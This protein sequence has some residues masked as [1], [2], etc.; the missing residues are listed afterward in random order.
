MQKSGADALAQSL[1]DI[2][3]DWTAAP[4]VDPGTLTAARLALARSSIAA[5]PDVALRVSPGTTETSLATPALSS[6]LRQLAEEVH[7]AAG[8][9]TVAVVR[10]PALA[11]LANPT[12]VPGWASGGK[13]LDSYGPFLDAA[14]GLHWVDVLSITTSEQIG[15]GGAAA[16]FGVVPVR[17]SLLPL[18]NNQLKLGAGSVW[19]LASLLGSGFP[20]GA[21]TGFA[22]TG[23]T[24]V[25][26][27]PLTFQN[28]VYEAPAG[29]TLTLTAMLSSSAASGTGGSPDAAAATAQ[30]PAD[31]VIEF[32]ASTAVLQT[33]GASSMTAYG[34]SVTLQW[35]GDTPTLNADILEIPEI[36][37]PCTAS[38]SDFAFAQALSDAFAP[39]GSAPISHAAWTFPL[40][41]T[42]I[43][44]LPEAAGPG[45]ARLSLGKGATLSCGILSDTIAISGWVLEIATGTLLVAAAS[46]GTPASTTLSLWPE[47]APAG[48]LATLEFDTV[49]DSVFMLVAYTN[50]E[51]THTTGS[52][53]AHLDRPLDSSGSRIPFNSRGGGTAGLAVLRSQ[54]SSFAV[55]AATQPMTALPELSLTLENALLRVVS[56]S[57]LTASGILSGTQ[58]ST[59]VLSEAFNIAWILP[60]LPDPYAATFETPLTVDTNTASQLGTLIATTRWDGSHP[61]Q[62]SC[63]LQTAATSPSLAIPARAAAANQDRNMPAATPT[64]LY[65]LALLD[66]STNVDLFGVAIAPLLGQLALT[67]VGSIDQPQLAYNRLA[68]GMAASTQATPATFGV[69]DMTLVFNG[70]D[71]ATFA[72]PQV[73]W[74]AVETQAPSPDPVGPIFGPGSDGPPLLL[75]A[76]DNQQLVALAPQPVLTGSISNVAAGAPFAAIFSLPFGL[77]GVIAE[78]NAPPPRHLGRRRQP[79]SQFLARGGTF[80]SPTSTFPLN[81]STQLSA[82]VSLTVAPTGT[83]AVNGADP[84]FSGFLLPAGGEGAGTYLSNILGPPPVPSGP[85]SVETILFGEFGPKSAQPGVPLERIDFSGYGTSIFSEWLN[86]V[87]PPP[88]IVKVQFETTRGR[89][90]YEVIQVQ[91]VIYPYAISVVRTI[92]LQ[93]RNAGWVLRTDSGWQPVSDGLFQFPTA[94][95]SK[96]PGTVHQGALLG[97]FNVRNIAEQGGLFAVGALTYQGVSFDADLGVAGGP[98]GLNVSTGGLIDPSNRMQLVPSQQILGYVQLLPVGEPPSPLQLGQLV[99]GHGPFTPAVSFT[100]EVGSF[101]PGTAGTVLRCSAFEVGVLTT[102]VSSTSTNPPLGVALR[103]APQMPRGGGW[104]MGVRNYQNQA[105]SSL[106]DDFPVPLVQNNSTPDMW[107]IADVADIGSLQQPANLYS[108]IHATGTNKVLFEAPQIPA[109]ASAAGSSAVPGL[110]FPPI[111]SPQ[112]GAVAN[113]GS[114][115]LGDLASILGSSGLFPALDSALSLFKTGDL[116]QIQTTPGG[117]QYS[118]SY[119]FPVDSKGNPT[120]TTPIITLSNI[121]KITLVYGDTTGRTQPANA[122]LEY[123]V[124]S[125]PSPSPLPSPSWTLSLGPLSAQ[126]AVP[127]FGTV[128][129]ITGSFYAD[130]HTKAGLTNLNVTFGGALALVENVFSDLQVLAAYLPGGA[131]ANLDVSVSGGQLSVSDTFT[132]ADLPLGLGDLTD[133]SLDLG[134]D[135]TLSPQSVNFLVGLG[136]PG[137]PFNWIATPLAGNGFMNFGVQDNLPAFAIQAGIGLGC[138]IALAIAD[139]SASI[140]IALDLDVTTDSITLVAILTGQASVTLLDGVAS[141]S[142]T[143]SASLGFSISPPPLPT[144]NPPPLTI[145]GGTLD[146]LASCSVGIHI[147]ICW[148]VNVNWEGAW[149]FKESFQTPTLTVT[150]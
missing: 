92:M 60:T 118:K 106:P 83:S 131:G 74:E 126:V 119:D 39:A 75:A 41:A 8:P 34:T 113:P 40:S 132:V 115:N 90:A 6:E 43:T 71:V 116:P 36:Q 23:G 17:I 110:Q 59:G 79:R 89:T 19:F 14:G 84:I 63:S 136:S 100:A 52:L 141:A 147:S 15:F 4:G 121:I 31:V 120:T 78:P 95:G 45:A 21:F 88:K 65:P 122:T 127:A 137:N 2:T 54:A 49:T 29:S 37:I 134:L 124:N 25:C 5:G 117:I 24:L 81:A 96:Y 91:S 87:G 125:S 48:R 42:T 114:P 150:I 101:G 86:G 76:P 108:L 35:T 102:N 11:G 130:E 16:P 47:A 27:Q 111:T 128:L 22:I 20:A 129:T 146:L 64:G 70:A 99:S 7:A 9:T 144:N 138:A 107:N 139:G 38:R 133:V 56:P 10:S 72:L 12:G 67:G 53:I 73:S 28:G 68:E 105:P 50:A 142:I 51:V 3:A 13:V 148:V 82:A 140:T 112:S 61:P 55:V 33:V 1:S 44:A 123:T 58:L 77:A 69:S 145:P 109:T 135:V 32:T 66:L 30:P 57:L 62:M 26:T 143:L 85:G 104:S 80:S 98:T 93:R 103:G 149:Q 18:P 94:D 97:V 46:A